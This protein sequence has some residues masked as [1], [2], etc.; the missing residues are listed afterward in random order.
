[1]G[2]FLAIAQNLEALEHLDL[3]ENLDLLEQM[4]ILQAPELD[5]TQARS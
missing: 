4:S 5:R 2:D 1:M 3:A